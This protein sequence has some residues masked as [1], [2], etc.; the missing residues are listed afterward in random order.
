M[1]QSS[2]AGDTRTPA[3]RAEQ[4]GRGAVSKR[5]IAQ[6]G[7][8]ADVAHAASDSAETKPFNE[9]TG[10]ELGSS[11]ARWS[12]RGRAARAERH[13]TGSPSPA[14]RLRPKTGLVC[15]LE[16]GG[17][18]APIRAPLKTRLDRKTPVRPEVRESEARAA[19]EAERRDLSVGSATGGEVDRVPARHERALAQT[20]ST[21]PTGQWSLA[22][23]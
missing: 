18:C 17:V 1:R 3:P 15:V 6:R 2:L 10:A 20:S 22:R 9:K 8:R 11:R 14:T 7:E 12:E 23:T 13:F 5:D 16:P 21:M 4:F 19:E